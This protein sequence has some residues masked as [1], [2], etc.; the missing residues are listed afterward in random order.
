MCVQL[1]FCPYHTPMFNVFISA[2]CKP[3]FKK[4]E[5][6]HKQKCKSLQR[7]L[8]E[9]ILFSILLVYRILISI[10]HK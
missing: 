2:N 8:F 3:D 9:I 7:E 1:Y 10:Q 6:K 4:K 5:L